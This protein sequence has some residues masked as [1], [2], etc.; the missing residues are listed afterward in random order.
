V[1]SLIEGAKK[2]AG[3]R[4]DLDSRV[5]GLSEAVAATRGRLDDAVVDAAAGVAERASARLG[6]SANHTVVALAG[7]TGSGKSSTFNALT[8]LDLA[9]VGVRRPTTSWASACIWGPNGASELLEWLG[10]PARHQIV[11]D[12]MLDDGREV[13]ELQ[14]LVLLDCPDHDST[15]V[16]HH[17]EVNR[18]ISMTDLMVW[19]VDPQKYADAALHDG[20]LRPLSDHG[21]VMLVVLNHIDEVPDDRRASMVADL[22]GLLDADGL[23]EVPVLV[24]SAKT[25]EG[26]TELRNLIAQRVRDKATTRSRFATD[27]SGAA[28]KL[29]AVNGD[30]KPPS[31]SERDK[32]EL[33][34]AV[35]D[36]AGVPIVVEAVHKATT[37]RARRATGWPLTA[38]VSKLRPDPLKRL[39]LDLGKDLV[40]SA[41][42]SL[43]KAS[44]VQQA[45]VEAAVRDVSDQLSVD[46]A[47]PWA[48]AVRRASTSRFED[49][50]DAL[51]RAISTADLG[52]TRTPL[53]CRTV[54]VLQWLLLLAAIGGAGWLAALAVMR[55]LDTTKPTTPDFQGWPLPLILLVLGVGI[56]FVLAVLSRALINIG[57]K[58][59]SRKASRRLRAAVRQVTDD[60]VIG[61]IETELAAYARAR[62]GLQRARG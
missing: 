36:S 60:L 25:G 49:L 54:R 32:T 52:V 9:A 2:L 53:W 6:L 20:F 56:G 55:Y 51:D 4:T 7:A 19:V 30:A 17:L 1:P 5:S 15:E 50:K 59:R 13:R 14:G 8:G 39:H 37:I 10:I 22:R 31:L 42:S 16:S 61:P 3:R 45:R 24:T 38:W 11:R 29:A 62:E 35:S 34:D 33:V 44:Y 23:S 12:S 28:E 46:L 41:R 47:R 21:N 26:M 48:H 40:S 18:L 43:P 57:S 27:I 58:G